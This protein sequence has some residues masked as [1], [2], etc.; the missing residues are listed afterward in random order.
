MKK[1]LNLAVGLVSVLFVTSALTAQAG[2][3]GRK[4]FE[5]NKCTMCHSIKVEKIEK[6]GKS[7]APDLSTVGSEKKAEWIQ[8]FLKK[9]ET[10]AGKKHAIAFKGTD[11]ELKTV[12]E[13]LVKHK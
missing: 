9:E 12:A 2:G 13:W 5:S 4:I 6:S 10:N 3:D 1:S 11:A 7:N 8:K